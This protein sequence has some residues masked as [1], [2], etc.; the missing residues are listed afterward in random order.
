MSSNDLAIKAE[1]ISKLYRIGL[2]EE[3]HDNFATAM[4]KLIKSPSIF[5][6]SLYKKIKLLKLLYIFLMS[7]CDL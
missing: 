3:I 1:N 6:V 4:L 2:K 7:S 5:I